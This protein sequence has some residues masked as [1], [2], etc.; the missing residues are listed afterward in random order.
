MEVMAIF[1]A[2]NEEGKT[3]VLITHEQDISEYARRIVLFRYGKILS[4][5]PVAARRQA[6]LRAA[7]G[8]AP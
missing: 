2:L 8:G 5:A 3:I 1:Q 6:V 7:G 4:D